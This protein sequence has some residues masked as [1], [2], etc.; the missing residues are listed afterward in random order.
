MV[1]VLTEVFSR[2]S[3]SQQSATNLICLVYEYQ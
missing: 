1:K 2:A 3:G